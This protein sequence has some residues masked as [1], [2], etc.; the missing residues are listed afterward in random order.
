LWRARQMNDMDPHESLQ[1][2]LELTKDLP[3]E[4]H[5]IDVE[6]LEF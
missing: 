6:P 1:F 4:R 2:L 3:P 5:I